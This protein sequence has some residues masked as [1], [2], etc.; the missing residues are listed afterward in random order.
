MPTNCPCCGTEIDVTDPAELAGSFTGIMSRLIR[1]MADGKRKSIY[2]MVA[3]TYADD[4]TGG[5][6]DAGRSIRV[7]LCKNRPKMRSSGWDILG[8]SGRGGGY[9]LVRVTQ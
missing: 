5:P 1:Y 8:Y 3:H 9:R 6:D 2:Q 4:P 7:T